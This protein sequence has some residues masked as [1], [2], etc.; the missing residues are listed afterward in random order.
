MNDC[1]DA[2][3]VYKLTAPSGKVYI[4]ITM[5]PLKKRFNNGHGYKKCHAIYAA[6]KKYGWKNFT[7]EILFDNLTKE[8]AELKEIELISFYKSNQKQYGYNIENGGNVT[9]T[10]SEETKRKISEGNKGKIVSA[11][12]REKL[13]KANMGKQVGIDNPFY[14]RHHTDKTKKAHSDFMKGNKYNCGNHHTEEFKSWKSK[15]MKRAYA[16]GKSPRCKKV[17]HILNDGTVEKFYS[18]RFAAQSMN[19]N[20]A[21]MH[22]LVNDENC[23][24]WRYE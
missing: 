5:Q 24:E 2:Y 19:Y 18:L 20:L 12:T 7:H 3:K 6:I 9:G 15:Q 17:L 21:K 11:E 22:K 4:G 14:G 23:K 13:K 10:H 1:G 8:T 16:D